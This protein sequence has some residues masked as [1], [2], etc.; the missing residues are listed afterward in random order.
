MKSDIWPQYGLIYIGTIFLKY[1]GKTN[2]TRRQYTTL[3]KYHYAVCS[4]CCHSIPAMATCIP[5]LPLFGS[6]SELLSKLNLGKLLIFLS[7]ISPGLPV[8]TSEIKRDKNNM[9]DLH[10]SCQT[11]YWLDQKKKKKNSY[12]F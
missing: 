12:C 10:L 5:K 8:G 1:V 7:G 11:F 3:R 9:S 2:G 6:K 4:L